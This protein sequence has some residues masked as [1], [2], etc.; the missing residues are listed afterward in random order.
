MHKEIHLH[1]TPNADEPV[2][3]ALGAVET[4]ITGRRTAKQFVPQPVPRSTIARLI[5][6]AVWAPNHRLNEPWRFYV[7]DG[8]S[9]TQ[10]AKIA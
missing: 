5:E 9:R 6:A 2:P 7:L 3:D 10:L 8:A 4:V 1:P